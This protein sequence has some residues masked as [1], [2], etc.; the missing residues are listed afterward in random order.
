MGVEFYCF[1]DIFQSVC[2]IA[3]TR[4]EPKG[5][6]CAYVDTWAHAFLGLLR[7]AN[8]LHN[9]FHL[10]ECVRHNL[11]YTQNCGFYIID[12]LHLAWRIRT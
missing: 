5:I 2:G 9:R 12:G 6:G 8:L 1:V 7:L 3:D 11:L 10:N 4:F